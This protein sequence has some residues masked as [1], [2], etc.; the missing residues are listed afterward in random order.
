M[1]IEFRGD[2]EKDGTEEGEMEIDPPIEISKQEDVE[3]QLETLNPSIAIVIEKSV[4]ESIDNEKIAVDSAGV[5]EDKEN[6]Q[7]HAIESNEQ[8][9]QEGT[10]PKKRKK[11]EKSR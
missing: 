11:F 6:E 7:V 4:I 3:S 1:R 10:V 2:H 5:I 8:A 9:A